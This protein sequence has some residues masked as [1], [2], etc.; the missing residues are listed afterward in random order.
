MQRLMEWLS[1]NWWWASA[2]IVALAS[3]LNAITTHWSL[4]STRAGRVLLFI[5][6]M[7]SVLRSRGVRSWGKLPLEDAEPAPR[8]WRRVPPLP[9][10][11][12]LV[13][14]SSGCSATLATQIYRAH[15]GVDAASAL[16]LTAWH[17]ECGKRASA[18][19]LAKDDTCKPLQ[20]CQ[21][22]R[23][24]FV[25]AIKAVDTGLA[26]ANRAAWNAGMGE[27]RP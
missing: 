9:L 11:L 25:E 20:D 12:L 18:C 17:A 24:A 22:S 15:V 19:A 16:A 5:V 27:M 1:V 14:T 13:L 2:A 8:D 26:L 23:R 3:L 10:L 7:L 6:E 4:A 21:A